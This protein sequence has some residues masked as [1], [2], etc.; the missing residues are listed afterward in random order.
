MSEQDVATLPHWSRAV[1]VRLKAT[2]SVTT[3]LLLRIKCVAPSA[4]LES[5][6]RV[7]SVRLLTR[8]EAVTAYLPATVLAL[9]AMLATP[10]SS[11]T[12]VV[13]LG[14]VADAPVTGAL[15]FTVTPA[16]TGLS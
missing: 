3:G 5:V 14:K 7:E 11:V 12:A 2:P 10:L 8:R 16:P 1:I 15:K 9:T 6:N 13:P 4:R